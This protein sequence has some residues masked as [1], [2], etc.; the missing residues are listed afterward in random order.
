MG[1]RH[2]SEGVIY[3]AKRGKVYDDTKPRY[4]CYSP[5]D[6]TAYSLFDCWVCDPKGNIH[7][8]YRNSPVPV[9][10]SDIG[11]EVGRM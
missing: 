9:N 3:R 5:A 1:K 8:G 6:D 11:K 2:F 4:N 7:P 10:A